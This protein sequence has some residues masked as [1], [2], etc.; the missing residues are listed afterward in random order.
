MNGNQSNQQPNMTQ[1]SNANQQVI[2]QSQNNN[3]EPTSKNVQT[4]FG[5]PTEDKKNINLLLSFFYD[6]YNF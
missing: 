2:A 5:K 6:I 3:S 4:E 1:Q